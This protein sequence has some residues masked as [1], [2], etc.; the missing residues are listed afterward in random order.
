MPR[1]L[2]VGPVNTFDTCVNK[3]WIGETVA[4]SEKKART[5]LEYQ[6]KKRLGLTADAKVKLPGKI[7]IVD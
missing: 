7:A 5:N 2:Y 4:T 1:Y 3:R 6:C